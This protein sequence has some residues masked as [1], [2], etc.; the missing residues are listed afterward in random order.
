MAG[1]YES[2]LARAGGRRELARAEPGRPGRDARLHD[3]VR[4]QARPIRG[5]VPQPDGSDYPESPV[6]SDPRFLYN[7]AAVPQTIATGNAQDD[8]GLFVTTISSNIADL[9]Y[10]PFENAGAISHWHLDMQQLNN[11]VDLSTVGDVVLHLYYTALDGGAALQQA[12][13]ANNLNTLPTSGIK[14]FSAQNDFLRHRRAGPIPNPWRP[15]SP[16]CTHRPQ[17]PIKCSRCRF[18][19]RSSRHGPAARRSLSPPLL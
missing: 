18:R 12:A 14:V 19:R 15:G 4:R 9:R 11:E 2:L 13:Q 3:V 17:A 8:P 6:G 1:P 5:G 16:S 10:L 7:Y